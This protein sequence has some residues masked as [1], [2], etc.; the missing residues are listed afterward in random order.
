MRFRSLSVPLALILLYFVVPSVDGQTVDDCRC[1]GAGH[2]HG[3]CGYHLSSGSNEDRPWCRTSN[4][5]G[6][7]SIKGTWSYCDVRGV[8][9]RYADD[10]QLYTA[11]DFQ[12]YYGTG[13][14]EKWKSARLYAERR[15]AENKWAY[16]AA[17]MRA[18]YVDSWGE[19]GWLHYWEKAAPEQRKAADGDWY[20][21]R[22]FIKFDATDGWRQWA[23]ASGTSG[24]VVTWEEGSKLTVP[25]APDG[26]QCAGKSVNKGQCGYHLDL[27]SSNDRPWCRTISSCGEQSLL[28]SW[29]YCA[30]EAV[31]R[32]RIMT[33]QLQGSLHTT[34]DLWTMISSGS[35]RLWDGAQPFAERRMAGGQ[36][37]DVH[38]FR[39][40]YVAA[41]GEKGWLEKWLSANSEQRQAQ[42]GKWYTW[43]QFV[44]HYGYQK[45]AQMWA[46]EHSRRM[47]F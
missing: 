3:L 40:Y 27:A 28:G 24:A 10:G 8:E 15:V 1:K 46:P 31:E 20:D 29:S 22:Q 7:N 35:K 17:D 16:T 12:T 36:A 2:L 13:G 34:R 33:P 11:K 47:E 18:H 19:Q 38:E 42:D 44:E 5:C 21:F 43:E 37:Y 39:A 6:W 4:N 14:A 23:D 25:L 45:A 9:R 41:L 30:F 26:C 32:R